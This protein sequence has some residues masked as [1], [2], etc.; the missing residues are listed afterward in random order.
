MT[1]GKWEQVPDGEVKIEAKIDLS[2]VNHPDPLKIIWQQLEKQ[3]KKE[4]KKQSQTVT[5]VIGYSPYREEKYEMYKGKPTQD[6]PPTWKLQFS[7]IAEE[8]RSNY[9]SGVVEV[10]KSR[11]SPILKY[12]TY[13]D[14]CFWPYTGVI[15]KQ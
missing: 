11:S 10:Y 14:G 6:I 15:I 8:L 5:I 2:T 13:R 3:R 7:F 9:N 12:S 4:N 1:F